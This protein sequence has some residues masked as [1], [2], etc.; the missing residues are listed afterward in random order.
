MMAVVRNNKIPKDEELKF[1]QYA[2]DLVASA[3]TQTFHYMVKSGLAYGL[4]TTGEA[5]VFL[6]MDWDDP[7]TVYYP[8]CRAG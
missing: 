5:I 7:T 1:E 6:K 8:S 2:R 3:I 4:L